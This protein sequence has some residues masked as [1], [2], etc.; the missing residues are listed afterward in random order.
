MLEQITETALMMDA[1][2]ARDTIEALRAGINNVR[3]LVWEL[4]FREGWRALGYQSWREC[5]NAEF[6][7][8]Q[9]YLYRQLAAAK[10]ER[11]ISP[12]GEI[13]AIPEGQ[14]RALT[15]LPE[16][17]R[18]QAWQEAVQ[19]TDGNVTGQAVAQIVEERLRGEDRNLSTRMPQPLAVRAEGFLGRFISLDEALIWEM[20]S[21]EFADF[22]RCRDVGLKIEQALA[23]IEW[24]QRDTLLLWVPAIT[25]Q[26]WFRRLNGGLICF[27]SQTWLTECCQVRLK[28]TA[29]VLLGNEGRDRFCEW[30]RGVGD[31]YRLEV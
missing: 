23:L 20:P 10:T 26:D 16:E 31:I 13:G 1:Q 17:Q 7:E 14:L 4:E 25:D 29:L 22:T 5:V 18:V 8:S 3:S 27:V 11:L 12:D 21:G 30:F 24:R 6:E 19:I 2:E 9:S 15:K 28:P